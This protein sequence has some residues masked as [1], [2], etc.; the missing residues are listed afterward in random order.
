[1]DVSSLVA[2]MVPATRQARGGP[3]RRRRCPRGSST[4]LVVDR[5]SS[6]SLVAASLAVALVP[7]LTLRGMDTARVRAE[8]VPGD[9]SRRIATP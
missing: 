7:G 8:P 3:V 9:P 2:A 5:W 4:Q 6:P 1:M